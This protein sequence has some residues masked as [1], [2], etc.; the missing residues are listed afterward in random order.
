MKYKH[1]A[2]CVNYS[3]VCVTVK[4]SGSETL[5]I[6]FTCLMGMCTMQIDASSKEA[7]PICSQYV[8]DKQRNYRQLSRRL[9]AI[10]LKDILY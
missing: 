8:K 7:G 1:E 3:I 9:P 10:T 4:T 5:N 6:S 2:V